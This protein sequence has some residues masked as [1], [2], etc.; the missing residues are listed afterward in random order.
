MSSLMS[1]TRIG[2]R[3][4]AYSLV[5]KLED[6]SADGRIILKWILNGKVSCKKSDGDN[7]DGGR[8]FL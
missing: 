1:V 7:H 4:Y 8:T 3:M 5:V 6:L 2:D